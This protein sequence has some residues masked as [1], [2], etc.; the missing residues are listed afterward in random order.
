MSEKREGVLAGLL[1]AG[2]VAL[3]FLILDIIK[4]SPLV[5]PSVLGEVILLRNA[6]P[7]LDVVNPRAVIGYTALHLAVFMIL[8]IIVAK[9]VDLS[10]R[11]GI[12]RFALLMLFVVFEVFFYWLVQ[13]GFTATSGQF[14]LWTVLGANTL[15]AAVMGWWLY[16]RHPALKGG[17]PV[18]AARDLK[19][20]R[21]AGRRTQG[22]GTSREVV[23][24]GGDVHAPRAMRLAP[25]LT[26]PARPCVF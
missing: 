12:W 14:P 2:A 8:G 26:P 20:A 17:F 13:L 5:T 11:Y 19:E 18:V 24:E 21:G 16:R 6:S 22:A 15:A 10:E 25:F 9:L 3:W 1:G 7:S 4:G 23:T